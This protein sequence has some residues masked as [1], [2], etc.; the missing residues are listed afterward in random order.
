MSTLLPALVASLCVMSAISDIRARRVPNALLLAALVLGAF[1]LCMQWW[2]DH[3]GAPWS[4]LLGFLIGLLVFFPFYTIHR[5]GAGDVKLFA[6]LGFLMGAK[7]LLPIWIIASLLA[8]MH[9]VYV[10]LSNH[11]FRHVARGVLD[12]EVINAVTSEKK[13]RGTP[14][15]AFLSTG[16]L[17]TLLYPTLAHW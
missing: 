12:V 7:A 15:A 4:S 1:A 2:L 16:A 10:L 5:M 13:R 17:A 3:T 11:Q 9:V 14:Y 8:G 6:T